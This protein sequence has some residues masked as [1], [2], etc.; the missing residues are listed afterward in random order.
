MTSFCTTLAPVAESPHTPQSLLCSPCQ[1]VI[2]DILSGNIS[3]NELWRRE[4]QKN[5]CY[6][7]CHHA[8]TDELQACSNASGC[9]LCQIF[10]LQGLNYDIKESHEASRY[11]IKTAD[12]FR[13]F[14]IMRI[15][16]LR[17]SNQDTCF[18]L[19]TD[20]AIDE[21]DDSQPQG[22]SCSKI[23]TGPNDPELKFNTVYKPDWPLS[24]CNDMAGICR[25]VYASPRSRGCLALARRWLATCQNQHLA[26]STK[27]SSQLPT[28]VVDLGP[29]NLDSTP[30]LY[31]TNGETA[32]YVTLSYCWGGNVPSKTISTNLKSY[33]NGL[34]T[35][36]LP[37]TFID[38]M[39]LT[40]ELGF[41]YL[42]IDALCIV[43]DDFGDWER[44]ATLMG[45]IYFNSVFTI[46]ALDASKSSEGFL[47]ERP[48]PTTKSADI[49]SHYVHETNEW[50]NLSVRKL[51][52]THFDYCLSNRGWTLQERLLPP[53]LLHYTPDGMIWECRTHCVWEHGE[54]H[55]TT[56]MLKA[57]SQ[58][59]GI[60]DMDFLWQR[61]VQDYSARILTVPSDKLPAIA[62]V[63]QYFRSTRS[64]D[65]EY[66]AGIWRDT[67]PESLRWIVYEGATLPQPSVYRAP[68]WSWAAVEGRVEWLIE[69]SNEMPIDDLGFQLLDAEVEDSPPRS[70]GRVV[71]GHIDVYG[72]VREC[73]FDKQDQCEGKLRIEEDH[74]CV[75]WTDRELTGSRDCF[76][77]A[78]GL[79]RFLPGV[80]N[81]HLGFENRHRIWYL[82]LERVA[83][84]REI[85]YHEF[86]GEECIQEFKRLGIAYL[87]FEALPSLAELELT[88]IRLV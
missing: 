81:Y 75:C 66:L 8:D 14:S 39:F 82:V 58:F 56:G 62:G 68:S 74:T 88:A 40:R 9:Q 30:R 70:M 47:A 24:A 20:H 22:R 73:F 19:A 32:P 61:V 63:A 64:E 55:P 21:M 1:R 78:L 49:G 10:V 48:P 54:G 79:W 59:T 80:V 15:A 60:V 44:E 76:A 37:Q 36:E 5:V 45:N 6:V 46:S 33:Q 27:G 17:P 85:S 12:L 86:D 31:E 53:A 38:A 2:R 34:D 84:E 43:Q 28:R 42:W 25:N 87:D 35:S 23:V 69:T 51:K 16:E 13:S 72:M 67:I 83:Q 7:T 57:M 52:S 50:C 3:K 77:L 18:V 71:G 4:E 26:C 29:P 65:D 11:N 41:R